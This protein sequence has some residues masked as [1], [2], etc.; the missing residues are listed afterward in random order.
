MG[1]KLKE[2]GFEARPGIRLSVWQWLGDQ[3]DD[4]VFDP[5]IGVWVAIV[6]GGKG[7]IEWIVKGG[8]GQLCHQ[9]INL[10]SHVQKLPSVSIEAK[11]PSENPHPERASCFPEQLW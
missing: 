11:T 7:Q 2:S 10:F 5:L 8:L 9:A 1:R 3:A 6:W 4:L